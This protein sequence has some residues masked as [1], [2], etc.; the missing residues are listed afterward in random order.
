MT[1]PTTRAL[2]INPNTLTIAAQQQRAVRRFALWV[3]GLFG[4]TIWQA[5]LMDSR[6]PPLTLL[7]WWVF[8]I[9]IVAVMYTPRNAIYILVAFGLLGDSELTVWYPFRKNFSSAESLFYSGRAVSF[10]PFEI[11]LAL[12]I[13]IWIT[14]MGLQ[15]K[16][17]I[18]RGP[19]FWPLLIFTSFITF[20]VAYGFGRGGDRTIGL[21]EV[22]SIYYLLPIYLLVT[23]W[24]TRREHVNILLWAMIIPL[25][26]NGIFG[27]MYVANELHWKLSGVESIAEHSLSI[28]FNVYLVLF[29]GAWVFRTSVAKRT[30][31]TVGLPMV[32]LSYIANNRR[33]SFIAMGVVL[34]V[35][36]VLLFHRRRTAFWL[37]IPPITVLAIAYLAVFWNS[38]GSLGA[39][40]SA[41]RS[42]LGAPSARDAASNN[43]RLIENTNILY[44]IKLAPLTGVGFGQ[45]FHIL[46]P[47][48]DISFFVW[49]EYI[50]HNSILW[51]WMQ[52]GVGGFLSLMATIGMGV[53][54]A[55]RTLRRMPMDETGLIALVALSYIV[56]HFVFAYVDMSW[57]CPNMLMVGLAMGL[58]SALP[59]VA[60]YQPETRTMRWP[61]I[62]APRPLPG[63]LVFPGDHA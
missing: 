46:V 26:I 63:P 5:T 61:W 38:S 49:W 19:L 56:M 45:K 18:K 53:T 31:L 51:I 50:T 59:A 1:A 32:L 14:Q 13:I 40:A 39:P 52:T 30:V 21:W 9:A 36:A 48:A 37:I 41:I 23:N 20:G 62:P 60:A 47:M 10:S 35:L 16:W 55:T 27:T 6:L 12:A 24:I 33:A 57:D 25:F 7:A 58:A 42:V 43:Y 28:R 17:A 2:L 4:L 3:I 29:L 11:I 34:L 54:V 22:R 8:V 15:R 44:T